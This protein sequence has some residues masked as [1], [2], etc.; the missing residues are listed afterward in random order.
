MPGVHIGPPDESWLG[1]GGLLSP[2]AFSR[3][4]PTLLDATC[5]CVAFSVHALGAGD[6]SSAEYNNRRLDKLSS[7]ASWRVS[8]VT[9]SEI[10]TDG[11]VVPVVFPS[12]PGGALAS[13]SP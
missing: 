5:M 8:Q 1:V 4:R 2:P 9:G 12:A 3:L 7:V 11:P 6:G 13:V 10:R